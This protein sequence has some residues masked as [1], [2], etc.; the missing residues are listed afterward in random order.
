MRVTIRV[1]AR[2]VFATCRLLACWL[3]AEA[4]KS[5]HQ[6]EP[7]EI[8]FGRRAAFPRRPQQSRPASGQITCA[9]RP[10]IFPHSRERRGGQTRPELA[11]G[12]TRRPTLP[13]PPTSRSITRCEPNA[14]AAAAAADRQERQR[15]Q[16]D[17]PSDCRKNNPE[18]GP[19][20]HDK[21][22]LV[23]SSARLQ[24]ERVARQLFAAAAALCKL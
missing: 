24:I 15:K 21:W 3:V 12:D 22:P 19:K 5:L 2:H 7:K 18:S 23:V 8:R 9:A 6:G 4:V 11:G 16:Q 17:R 10:S 20:Q 13:R 14:A 1:S